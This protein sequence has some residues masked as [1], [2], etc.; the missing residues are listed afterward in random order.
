M[1]S[2]H[3]CV[4]VGQKILKNTSSRVA[5]ASKDVILTYKQS[6]EHIGM[7]LYLI[8]GSSFRHYFSYFLF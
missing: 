4:S 7:F 5:K 8:Q 2:L 6:L 3:V 1:Q